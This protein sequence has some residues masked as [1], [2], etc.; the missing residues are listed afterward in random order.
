MG[1]KYT[2]T[3]KELIQAVRVGDAEAVRCMLAAGV[4][5][6]TELKYGSSALMI[7]ASRGFTDVV[8]VLAQAG[9]KVNRRNRFGVS[10]LMEA[11]EKG[12]LDCVRKLVEYG[13]DI[14][15]PHNN[16]TTAL[17]AATMRR[18]VKTVKL[19][20]ELNADPQIANFDGWTPLKW[21]QSES[22]IALIEAL[23]KTCLV[24]E[25]DQS[26]AAEEPKPQEKL[27]EPGLMTSTAGNRIQNTIWTAFMRAAAHGDSRTVR[28]LAEDEG[29][30]VN[31]QSPNG[32]TAIIAATKNGHRETVFELI[33]LGADLSLPDQ[34][35]MTAIE[36]ARKRG[37][38]LLVNE[39]AKKLSPAPAE[40]EETVSSSDSVV[41]AGH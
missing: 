25:P 20:L 9:A 13:A 38:V 40:G 21:A 6:D 18:D 39:L 29:V 37:D 24:P 5:T 27:P 19:L 31:G 41:D 15:M 12:R 28:H 36:W 33:E 14:N 16:G 4:D 2:D 17:L 34:D 7:A 3:Q 32:T 1:V 22:N 11:V 10:A 30:E 8:E 23:E 26:G 35:G